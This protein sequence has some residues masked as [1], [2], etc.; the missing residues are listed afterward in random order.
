MW[1]RHSQQLVGYLL[2]RPLP[3]A[4]L[5]PHRE[6]AF[7]PGLADRQPQGGRGP[8]VPAFTCRLPSRFLRLLGKAGGPGP[9]RTSTFGEAL[10]GRFWDLG[11]PRYPIYTITMCSFCP[12]CRIRVYTAV[13]STMRQG[14]P[15]GHS[16]SLSKVS[17]GPAYKRCQGTPSSTQ[18]CWG[19][20]GQ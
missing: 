12:R 2:L 11:C 1:V 3:L 14:R 19:Q 7:P 20:E 5:H 18:G 15:C 8:G 10:L 6:G 9:G 13:K 16:L 17:W 4:W